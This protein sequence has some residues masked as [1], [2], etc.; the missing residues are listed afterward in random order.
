M[1]A[2]IHCDNMAQQLRIEVRLPEG[3]W[4][5]DVSRSLPGEVFRIEETMPL[6]KGRGT[7]RLS[8]SSDILSELSSHNGVDEVRDLGN[9]R[10]EVDI[11]PGGGGYIRPIREVGVI[12][13]SPFTVRDGWVDWTIECSAEK[14][15]SL[16]NMLREQKIPCRII[17]TRLTKSRM[18]TTR[19]RIVYDTAM[20]EGY[21]DTPRRITLTSLAKLLG[22][23]KSTL[24]V[25]LHKIE[26][27]IINSFSEYVRRNS[28]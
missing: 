16:V 21:W 14:G 3:H 12:P 19:Q 25:Q 13:K 2:R 17:S 8:A 23:S 10:Y 20:I 6:A 26:S 22:V 7:A 4:S 28:P 11:A 5:G 1:T 27:V 18:L 15:R 24:S 9:F